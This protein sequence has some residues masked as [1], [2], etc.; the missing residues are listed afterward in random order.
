MTVRRS[1]QTDY[2]MTWL[3]GK[4]ATMW[5]VMSWM[6]TVWRRL[7]LSTLAPTTLPPSVLS[8]LVLSTLARCTLRL[9]LLVRRTLL[10]STQGPRLWVLSTLMP[11]P[12]MLS[13]L[14][15]TMLMLAQN[16]VELM[17]PLAKGFIA[18]SCTPRTPWQEGLKKKTIMGVD[19]LRQLRTLCTTVSTW[20]VISF[21]RRVAHL[22]TAFLTPTPTL[23][24]TGVCSKSTQAVQQ[25]KVGKGCRQA[26]RAVQRALM[27]AG[28]VAFWDLL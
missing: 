6:G 15:L 7:V 22:S 25:M 4:R 28:M 13:M 23:W 3:L 27:I 10:M 11:I 17:V 1:P 5:C 19:M 21:L 16:L 9:R 20:R 14:V 24:P 26:Q 2:N 12:A 18:P 8:P